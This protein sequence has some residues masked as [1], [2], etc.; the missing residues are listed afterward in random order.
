MVM[1]GDM[2]LAFWYKGCNEVGALGDWVFFKLSY[3]FTFYV[4]FRQKIT[5]KKPLLGML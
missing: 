5:K 1:D 2:W 3:H 4:A